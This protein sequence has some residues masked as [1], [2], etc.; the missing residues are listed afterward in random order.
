MLRIRPAHRSTKS[1]LK[2]RMNPARQTSSTPAARKACV[3][4]SLEL[5]FSGKASKVDRFRGHARLRERRRDPPHRDCPTSTSAISAQEFRLCAPP[6]SVPS[7]W[8]RGPRSG[9]PFGPALGHRDSRPCV[10]TLGLARSEQ[11]GRSGSAPGPPTLA[12][13]ARHFR[14][15]RRDKDRHA[16]SA[17]EGAQHFVLGDLTRGR[18]PGKD[19]RRRESVKIERNGDIGSEHARKIVGIAAPS[20]MRESEN[21]LGLATAPEAAALRRAASG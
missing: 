14:A 9:W 4:L 6:R 15:L 17:V 8:S 21:A 12:P 7:C 20:D 19:R 18:E 11:A 2:M 1:A 5:R 13:R 10:T 16:K 3:E